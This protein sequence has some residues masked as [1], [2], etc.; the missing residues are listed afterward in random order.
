M[1]PP[2]WHETLWVR[3]TGCAKTGWTEA[4]ASVVVAGGFIAWLWLMSVYPAPTV[5]RFSFLSPIFAILLGHF[6]LGESLSLGLL[7]A[8]I[9]AGIGIFLINRKG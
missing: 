5:V 4:P 6:L 8:A 2:G 7:A 1:T 3:T 9:L